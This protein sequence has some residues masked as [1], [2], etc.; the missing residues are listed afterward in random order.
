MIAMNQATSSLDPSRWNVTEQEALDAW[1][2]VKRNRGSHGMDKVSLIAF[3]AKLDQNLYKIRNRL[4]AGSYFP[5][6]VRGK[7]IPKA[8]GAIRLLG[9]P[10]VGDRVAQTIITNRIMAPLESIFVSDSYGCR[11]GKSALDAVNKCRK[12]CW[13]SDWVVD[14][15]IKGYFDNIPHDLMMKALRHVC[16]NAW[17]LRY[18][19]RWLKAPMILPDGTIQERT[20]G[21]PQGGVISPLLANLFLHFTFDSWIIKHHPSIKFERYVDD[22]IVHCENEAQAKYI[23]GE[24]RGRLAQC[25]LEL[26]PEKTKICY[27]RDDLRTKDYMVN[28]FVFLGYAFKPR[29]TA[30]RA[31]NRVF[32]GFNPAISRKA[33]KKIVERGKEIRRSLRPD[34]ELDEVAKKV[35]P[36]LRGLINYFGRFF[37]SVLGRELRHFDEYVLTY[38]ARKKYKKLRSMRQAHRWLRFIRRKYPKTFVHWHLLDKKKDGV[39]RAV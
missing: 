28:S 4:N 20:K 22:V 1:K 36:I 10:T 34:M 11:P 7:E 2:Q 23:L 15:D 5:P 27:C 31:G 29:R 19:E 17:I 6:G 26:H 33:S 14:L 24:I 13:A 9:I 3:E 8:N 32:L 18:C 30:T 39:I 37:P 35:N 38:W 21:T 12:R 16:D 25:G